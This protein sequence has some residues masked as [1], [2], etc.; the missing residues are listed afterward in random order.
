MHTS[1]L[2]AVQTSQALS[3]E[4]AERVIVFTTPGC[5][6]CR[7]AKQTL[8]DLQVPYKVRGVPIQQI[9]EYMVYSSP[10]STGHAAQLCLVCA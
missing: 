6:Y 8:T 10:G 2:H 5:Q 3:S 9:D 4:T 1:R 7:K